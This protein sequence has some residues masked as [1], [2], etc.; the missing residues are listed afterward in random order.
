MTESLTSLP[1]ERR[2]QQQL[3]PLASAIA[4]IRRDVDR[5]SQYLL[6]K[7][8]K[9]PYAG[10]W[11]LVG[12]KWDFG[13]SLAETVVREV[14]EETGIDSVFL[15]L[16]TIVNYR[17]IPQSEKDHGGHF[18]LFVCD[19]RA[20]AGEAGERAEGEVLWFGMKDLEE[21]KTS[22]QIILTDYMILEECQKTGSRMSYLEVEV[23][24]GGE[25]S[26]ALSVVRFE[27]LG[28]D[29]RNDPQR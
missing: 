6:I 13:E 28:E 15:S 9:Q 17:M 27:K 19:L 14:K 20:T 24:A 23:I 8:V 29:G 2:W 18:L 7:R 1:L 16:K 10:K 26:E 25:C 21:L 5:I 12:G 3:Q 22:G 11:G 4:I